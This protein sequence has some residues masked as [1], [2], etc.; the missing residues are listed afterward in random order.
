[1]NWYMSFGYYEFIICL[2]IKGSEIISYFKEY[3]ERNSTCIIT[4]DGKLETISIVKNH[5]K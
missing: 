5:G 2:D 3:N 4:E 1:M